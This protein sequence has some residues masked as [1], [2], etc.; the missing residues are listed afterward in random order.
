MGVTKDASDTEIKKSYRQ[1]A[2]IYHPDKNRDKPEAERLEAEKM[3]KE[4]A[5]AYGVLSDQKKKHLYD[6]GQ[7]DYDGDQGS[8]FGGGVD[9]SDMFRISN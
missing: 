2:V 3:F 9:P 6:S 5:E 1:L 4:I 7:M 8:G